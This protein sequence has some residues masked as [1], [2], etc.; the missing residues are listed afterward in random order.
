MSIP[1]SIEAVKYSPSTL[2][3]TQVP[4]N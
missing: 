2:T 4:N 1:F 3:A